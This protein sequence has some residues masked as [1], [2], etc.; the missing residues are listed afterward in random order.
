[1]S[2]TRV[3]S[4]KA[5]T[6]EQAVQWERTKR[7]YLRAGLCHKCSAQAAWAHQRGAGGWSA[8]HPPC[9]GCVDLV[10]MLTYPTTNPLWRSVTRK[11]I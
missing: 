9:P 8:I 7:R 6:L 11:R 4:V 1:M 3:T 2:A 5:E 10:E